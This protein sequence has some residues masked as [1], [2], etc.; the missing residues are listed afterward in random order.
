MALQVTNQI[1]APAL[2]GQA[3]KVSL[4]Q[5]ETVADLPLLT[6]GMTAGVVSSGFTGKIVSIDRYGTSFLVAPDSP[7][8]NLSSAST[9]GILAVSELINID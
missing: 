1:A 7:A 4:N 5:A 3:V 2:R 6:V 9:P 8:G